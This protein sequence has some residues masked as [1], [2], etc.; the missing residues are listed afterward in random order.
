M[1]E[2]VKRLKKCPSCKEIE[3]PKNKSYCRACCKAIGRKYYG[4]K[5]N[6]KPYDGYIYV[7]TNKAWEGWVKIGRATD[8]SKRIGAYNTSSPYRDYEAVY[9]TKTKNP[10][11]IEMYFIDTY[12]DDN[13][14]WFNI[15]VEEAI[16]SIED[17]KHK[18]EI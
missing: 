4:E 11:I 10:F 12:G 3:I 2:T 17:L 7:I 5:Y 1:S 9:F 14:E 15:S 16:K 6:Y 8:V 13:N 18:H